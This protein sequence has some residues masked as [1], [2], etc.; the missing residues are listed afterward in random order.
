MSGGST[1]A[2]VWTFKGVGKVLLGAALGGFQA[3][4]FHIETPENLSQASLEWTRPAHHVSY[5]SW[6][7]A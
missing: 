4:I 1:L 7:P 2:G 5:N 3:F 6:H